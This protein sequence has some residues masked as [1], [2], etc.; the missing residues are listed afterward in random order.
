MCDVIREWHTGHQGNITAGAHPDCPDA[1]FSGNLPTYAR[2]RT[3]FEP[4]YYYINSSLKQIKQL[5][6][7]RKYKFPARVSLDRFYPELQ[8]ENLIKT[9]KLFTNAIKL[10]ESHLRWKII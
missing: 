3:N 8:F 9:T 10:S 1:V 4:W 2:E 5:K 7:E 6:L